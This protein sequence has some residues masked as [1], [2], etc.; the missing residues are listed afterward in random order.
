MPTN[1][2]LLPLVGGYWF[3]HTFYFTRYRSQR[4]DGYRLLVESALAGILLAFIA[5]PVVFAANLSPC[6]RSTWN[7]LAPLD[8]PYFGTACIA[9]LLG[10]IAPYGLNFILENSGLRSEEHT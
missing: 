7:A 3:I 9:A 6:I 4:L 2:L 10:F 8:F 5:R 1:L